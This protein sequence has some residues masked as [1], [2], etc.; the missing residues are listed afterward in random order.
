MNAVIPDSPDAP[1]GYSMTSLVFR[2]RLERGDGESVRVLHEDTG[3][4]LFTGPNMEA[5]L[6]WLEDSGPRRQIA[7]RLRSAIDGGA[8]P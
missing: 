7:K 4:L 8:L 2:L 5:A 3:G 6:K 1:L